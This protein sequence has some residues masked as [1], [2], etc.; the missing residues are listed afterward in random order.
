M[1]VAR[2]ARRRRKQAANNYR[3]M[4]PLRRPVYKQKSSSKLDRLAK[5]AAERRKI[6]M[7]RGKK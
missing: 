2:T 4:A 1:T 6:M 3:H 5:L 7:A